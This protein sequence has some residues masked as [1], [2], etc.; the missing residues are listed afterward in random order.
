MNG[1]CKEEKDLNQCVYFAHTLSHY[2]TELEWECI[3]TIMNMLM[4]IGKE[5]TMN[6]GITL[7]N[8]NQKWL[9]TLY[10]NKKKYNEVDPFSIFIDIALAC[11]IVV[12][13]TF[14]DGSIGAGVAKEMEAAI[15]NDMPTYILYLADGVKMFMPCLD[16]DNY[17]VLSRKETRRRIDAGEK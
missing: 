7:M 14:L 5:P 6:S 4:P 1:V 13:S 17:Q 3:E 11:D 16:I 9:H 10:M 2:D 15:K 8:P 12:G